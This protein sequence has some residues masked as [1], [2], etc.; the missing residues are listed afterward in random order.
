MT[1]AAEANRRGEAVI[2][3]VSAVG[4]SKGSQARLTAR[5]VQDVDA[6]TPAMPARNRRRLSIEAHT[7]TAKA[8][9]LA[10]GS[11]RAAKSVETRIHRRDSGA[12][13]TAMDIAA[14][15]ETGGL[16]GEHLVRGE[17]LLVEGLLR[18]LQRLNLGLDGDL[19]GE[20]VGIRTELS[21]SERALTCS[22]MIPEISG[23]PSFFL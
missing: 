14:R 21:Q 15:R 11:L 19:V 1:R 16:E 18:L 7:Q 13:D 4:E 2:E 12:V 22:A 5:L 23:P 8:P 9:E 20:L 6:V 3:T 10:H 17:L